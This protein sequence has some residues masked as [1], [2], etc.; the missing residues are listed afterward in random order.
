[1]SPVNKHN[2]DWV[3]KD[4]TKAKEDLRSDQPRKDAH[5]VQPFRCTT[6]FIQF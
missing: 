4:F 2:P 1:L 3:P 6:G 5:Y